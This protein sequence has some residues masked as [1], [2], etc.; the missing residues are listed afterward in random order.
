MG[1]R[2]R[3]CKRDVMVGRDGERDGEWDREH[4]EGS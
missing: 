1:A 3:A 2:G 4:G